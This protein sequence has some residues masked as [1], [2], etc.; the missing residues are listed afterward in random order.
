[1][2]LISWSYHLSL[3]L[4]VVV[5]FCC[6]G[7]HSFIRIITI[8]RRHRGRISFSFSIFSVL[9]AR[10][11]GVYVFLCD[12]RCCRFIY[13]RSDSQIYCILCDLC[14]WARHHVSLIMNNSTYIYIIWI[15]C[16]FVCLSV[17]WFFGFWFCNYPSTTI[18]VDESKIQMN[19]YIFKSSQSAWNMRNIK[20]HRVKDV[21]REK[22][23]NGKQRTLIYTI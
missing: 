11:V 10:I 20:L 9:W 16:L 8:I 12:V 3:S 22:E 21:K 14:E 5:M 18:N 6:A 13:W 1:M 19:F 23:K 2:L 17:C 7:T 4:V 15:R